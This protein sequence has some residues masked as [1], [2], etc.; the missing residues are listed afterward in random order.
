MSLIND[1]SILSQLATVLSSVTVSTEASDRLLFLL[2][3]AQNAKVPSTSIITQLLSRIDTITTSATINELV[4]LIKAAQLIEPHKMVSVPAIADLTAFTDAI[5]GTVLFVQAENAPYIRKSNGTWVLIDPALQINVTPTPNIWS[6]GLGFNGAL[7][8]NSTVNKSSP[9]SVVGG[10]TD[11]I[12][13]AASGTHSLA[14]RANGTL[15]SWGNNGAGQL[16]QNTV[17]TASTSSP[18]LVTGSIT[19]W[20]QVAAGVANSF[21]IRANGELYAWGSNSAGQLGRDT[22]NTVSTSSPVLVVGGIADWTQ[23]SSRNTH[24]IGLRANGTLYAWGT[25]TNGRLGDSNA[26]NRSSPVL[27]AGGYVNWIQASAGDQHSLA[28]RGNGTMWGWGN[29]TSGRLGNISTATTSSP[30]LV[31]GGI[32]NWTQAVA[33][34]QHS[35][36][37]RA[38]GQLYAWGTHGGNLGDDISILTDKSSPVLVLGGFTD[39]VQASTGNATGLTHSLGLRANG[40]LWAWGLNTSGQIGDGT[41]TSRLSPVSVT[42]GFTDWIQINAGSNHNLGIRG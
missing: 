8:D 23:V 21:A 11:W 6:W 30:V 7:G 32:V 22:G 9:V 20:V 31:A 2:K 5:V 41:I 26:V 17:T 27:V 35:L 18:N 36:G 37:I 3:T 34:W 19:N 29:N 40:T 28:V 4:L 33:G 10:F 24:C 15:Y 16:G 38:T 1:T 39:W 14:I 13:A 12:Q 25:G 42:G